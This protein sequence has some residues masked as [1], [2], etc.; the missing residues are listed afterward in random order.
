MDLLFRDDDDGDETFTMEEM[1]VAEKIETENKKYEMIVQDFMLE[2]NQYL[3]DLKMIIKVFR[4]PFVKLFKQSPVSAPLPH[5]T[6]F[7]PGTLALTC[8]HFLGY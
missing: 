2:E 7:S 8:Y 4:E 1:K 3:R 5:P 6:G